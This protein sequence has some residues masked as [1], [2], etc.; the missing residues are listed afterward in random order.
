MSA[1]D[2]YK[3]YNLHSAAPYMGNVRVCKKAKG[4]KRPEGG[5][6]GK[7]PTPTQDADVGLVP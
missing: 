2:T 6:R 5:F 3:K 1:I 4:E 7:C